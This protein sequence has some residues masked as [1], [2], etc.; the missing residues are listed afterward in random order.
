MKF[1]IIK[2]AQHYQLD[3]VAHVIAAQHV[4]QDVMVANKAAGHVRK[5]QATY[6]VGWFLSWLA[7]IHF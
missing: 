4:E 7:D 2:S 1:I 5:T 3:D 6:F